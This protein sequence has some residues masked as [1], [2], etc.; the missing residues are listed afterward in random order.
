MPLT[1]G[2]N[3]NKHEMRKVLNTQ[4]RSSPAII[5]YLFQVVYQVLIDFQEPVSLLLHCDSIVT[6]RLG[7]QYSGRWPPRNP[8]NWISF[9]Y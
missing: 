4:E 9:T 8:S 1:N 2:E 7:L 3:A 5:S 6:D